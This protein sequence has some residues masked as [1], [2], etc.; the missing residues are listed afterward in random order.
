[1]A[2][3][4]LQSRDTFALQTR[5]IDATHTFYQAK[6]LSNKQEDL[7]ETASNFIDSSFN[8]FTIGNTTFCQ[9]FNT[10]YMRMPKVDYLILSNNAKV[11]LLQLDSLHYP[12]TIII[13]GSNS[14]WK[15]SQWKTQAAGLPL[16]LHITA[17]QGAWHQKL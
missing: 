6:N 14:L 11:D 2:I 1:M 17:E 15:I 10:S 13:D 9:A 3:P 16:R 5:Y 4:V 12:K 7:A 8:C